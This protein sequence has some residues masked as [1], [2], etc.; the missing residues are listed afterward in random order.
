MPLARQRLAGEEPGEVAEVAVV[1]LPRGIGFAL[2]LAPRARVRA[3][4]KEGLLEYLYSRLRLNRARARARVREGPVDNFSRE[5]FGVSN[6]KFSRENLQLLTIGVPLGVPQI[7]DKRV[8]K[9]NP[10]RFK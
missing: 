3:R 7:A 10:F 9:R 1:L 6:C 2:R 4:S 5:A 8:G